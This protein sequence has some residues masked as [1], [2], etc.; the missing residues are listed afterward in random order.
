MLYRK[1][2][3]MPMLNDDDGA[4]N[5]G[6]DVD[7]DGKTGNEPAKISM[8]EKQLADRLARAESKA[9]RELIKALGF[10]NVDSLKTTLANL[11]AKED[12]E[13]SE[14]QKA[15]EENEKISKEREELLK[16]KRDL[17]VERE[18]LSKGVDPNKLD[19]FKKIVEFDDESKIS[20]A[21][22]AT[23]V[24]W[25]EFKATTVK[26][27]GSDFSGGNGDEKFDLSKMKAEDIAKNWKDILRQ[28]KK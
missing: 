9:Q 14:L 2:L 12:A 4:G 23:L 3:S 10:E 17:I 7:Q 1:L 18:A 15:K 8:T 27:A 24:E 28:N 11:K 6:N 25:P 5:G 21:V 26:K 13:K 22:E 19:K 20:E 16:I